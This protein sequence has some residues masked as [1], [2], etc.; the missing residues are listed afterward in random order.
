MGLTSNAEEK[1]TLYFEM[2][3]FLKTSDL[4]QSKILE[5]D[6]RQSWCLTCREECEKTFERT[7]HQDSIWILMCRHLEPVLMSSSWVLELYGFG[8]PG[9]IRSKICHLRVQ[10]GCIR[11]ARIQLRKHT[12]TLTSLASMGQSSCLI[13]RWQLRYHTEENM[14]AAAQRNLWSFCEPRTSFLHLLKYSKWEKNWGLRGGKFEPLPMSQKANSSVC[15]HAQSL[16]DNG[17]VNWKHLH[18]PRLLIRNI[19]IL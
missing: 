1:E 10:D 19:Q 5:Q 18:Y 15:P 11:C 9:I 13:F 14:P 8:I 12:Q 4:L 16:S 2:P 17:F 6:E 7:K 3:N